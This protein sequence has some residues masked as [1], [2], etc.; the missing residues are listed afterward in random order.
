MIAA[1]KMIR[2]KRFTK[3]DRTLIVAMGHGIIG[4]IQGIQNLGRMIDIVT[5]SG[6][7]AIMV[8]VG[9]I[10]NYADEISGKVGL[11]AAVEYDEKSVEEAVRVGSDAV[12]TTYFG[13]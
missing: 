6:A 8:N 1:G 12:K 9:I 7:D 5:K 2:L 13:R 3:D 11:V 10:R 4:V